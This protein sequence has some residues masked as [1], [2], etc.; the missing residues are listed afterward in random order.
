MFFFYCFW[1]TPSHK[2]TT[3]AC[4]KCSKKYLESSIPFILSNATCA[5][6]GNGG[7]PPYVEVL[8]RSLNYKY[9]HKKVG[10]HRAYIKMKKKMFEM[11]ILT[12]NFLLRK[13]NFF[14]VHCCIIM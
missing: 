12:K 9:K 5:V 3:N 11:I 6:D 4:I 14:N 10:L 1:N 2:E 13:S 8:K 7:L